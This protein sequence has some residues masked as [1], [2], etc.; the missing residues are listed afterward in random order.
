[1]S[2]TL[3]L[4]AKRT[5]A[6][7]LTLMLIGSTFVVSASA[8]LVD[9]QD[10]YVDTTRCYGYLY[11][12]GNTAS[13]TTT[14]DRGRSTIYAKVSVVCGL[15][16]QTKTRTAQSTNLAGG[17]S[18]TAGTQEWIGSEALSASGVHKVAY[19]VETEINEPEWTGR[20]SWER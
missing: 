9:S 16:Y 17:A 14:Y 4:Y 20:T 1:M 19:H 13:A 12:D 3:K 5:F 18:A 8:A 7:L 15:G 10:G 6:M 11:V 2:M